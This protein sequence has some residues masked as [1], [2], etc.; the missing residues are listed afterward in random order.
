MVCKRRTGRQSDDGK[1]LETIE[2][3]LEKTIKRVLV[4]L[5]GGVKWK[6]QWDVL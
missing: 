3:L 6:G 4:P 2:I 5:V 1:G